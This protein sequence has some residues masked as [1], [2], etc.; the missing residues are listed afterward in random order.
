M[1]PEEL[2]TEM[3]A[4]LEDRRLSRTERRALREVLA[5]E[6]LDEP[7]RLRVEAALFEIATR[8][9][10][11]PRDAAIV[12]WL[13]ASLAALREAPADPAPVAPSHAWFGPDDPLADTLAALLAAAR[14]SVDVCV[15]TITDDRIAAALEAAHSRGVRVRIVT[16]DEKSADPGSDIGRLERRG[17]EVRS[18]ASPA[19][20][21]HKYAVLDGE[22]LLTGSYNWTRAAAEGNHE[23]LLATSDPAL[24]RAYAEHFERLWARFAFGAR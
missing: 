10:A 22:R 15:F 1:K 18:D 16:D 5:E 12:A 23:N 14:A 7:A 3:A 21:H 8:A 13:R 9:L 20:M 19:W 17:I 4:T 2:I 11:D 6:P 24:V